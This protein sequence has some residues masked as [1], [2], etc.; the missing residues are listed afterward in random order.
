MI[1]GT[2][3]SHPITI[4]AHLKGDGDPFPRNW[5]WGKIVLNGGRPS[6]RR[7]KWREDPNDEIVIPLDARS[8]GPAR[9]ILRSEL[10]ALCPNPR[11]SLILPMIV[12]R[13]EFFIGVPRDSATTLLTA[14]DQT[15]RRQQRPAS[16][17]SG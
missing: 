17:G 8:T 9:P 13:T 3:V 16:P 7:L 10:S 11:K 15:R 1:D 14:L 5:R 4:F 12:E 2:V 6:F